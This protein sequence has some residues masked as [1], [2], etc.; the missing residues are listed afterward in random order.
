MPGWGIISEIGLHG[1]NYWFVVWLFL[2]YSVVLPSMVLP[3][4]IFDK[5]H[6]RTGA[7]FRSF[8]PRR[9]SLFARP[10]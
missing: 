2:G 9:V 8:H 4:S 7:S 3:D 1:K 6:P 10:V 5:P